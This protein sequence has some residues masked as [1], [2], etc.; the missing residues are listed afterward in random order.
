L[1]SPLARLSSGIA[2]GAALLTLPA[3]LAR[4]APLG[5]D[6]RKGLALAK[7][8][9]CVKAMPL[10]EKAEEARHTPATA[11]A[12]AGCHL[13]LGDLLVAREIYRGVA[14]EKPK[15]DWSKDDRRANA[16]ARDKADALDARIP[17]VTFDVSPRVPGIEIRVGDLVVADP[18]DGAPVPPDEKVKI[19]IRADG[20]RTIE[21]A[22]T[23]PERARKR[24]PVHLEKLG[25]KPV[26]PKEPPHDRPTLWLGGRF[27]GDILPKFWM[28]LVADG[29]RT[30]FAPGAEVTLTKRFGRFDLEPSFGFTSYRMGPTPMKP[31]GT[32]NTEWEI[33]ESNLLGLE[34][35]LGMLYRLPLDDAETVSLRIGGGVGVGW[36]SFGDLVRTQAYPVGN[37]DDPA[38]YRKCVAPNDPAGTFRYCNQLDK[39]AKRYGGRPDKS[40]GDGG[41]RPILYPWVML[42]ELGL[43]IDPA[44]WVALDLD[45]GVTLTGFVTGAGV[46]FGL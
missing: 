28:N 20:Y 19:E 45:F 14:D 33:V 5:P 35:K 40:W 13:S 8:G 36:A 1:P 31:H 6:A 27:R 44:R 21:D 7:K 26:R 43:E 34:L 3:S 24:Y 12:L 39:D 10:L 9:D 25:P 4:A 42:P 15:K 2:L 18:E 30:L 41:L 46:R 17:V 32:P 29:G 11:S 22:I 23:L 16:E 37:P 38:S